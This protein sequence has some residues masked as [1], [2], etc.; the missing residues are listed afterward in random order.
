M[1]S[2]KKL[3]VV[4]VS[5]NSAGVIS[6]CISS[7]CDYFETWVVDNASSDSV[8]A[9]VRESCVSS[10]IEALPVNIG[11]GRAINHVL[12][13]VTSEYMLVLNPDVMISHESVLQLISLAD[14]NRDAWIISPRLMYSDGRIQ[15]SFLPFESIFAEDL[16]CVKQVIG[17]VM[18]LRRGNILWLGGF[19]ERLFLYGEDEDLCFR[20][21]NAG[22]KVCVARDIF[23]IHNYGSSSSG[24]CDLDSFKAWH[25]SWARIYVKKKHDGLAVAILYLGKVTAVYGIKWLI[26]VV[27]GNF[28]AAKEAASRIKG[29]YASFYGK[30]SAL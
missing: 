2:A 13:K 20:V 6:T 8:L 16:Q 29:A 21:N 19:D 14:E 15:R 10:I 12:N 28:N 17:A 5:Y 30:S 24:V 7:L 3:I 23:A 9:K 26:S 1:L 25:L 27:I 4:I 11:F 22:G 18:L